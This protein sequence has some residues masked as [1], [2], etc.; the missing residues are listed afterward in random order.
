VG[1]DFQDWTAF[2]HN[3][4]ARPGGRDRSQRRSHYESGDKLD[5]DG[6]ARAGDHHGQG[7][8]R[9]RRLSGHAD[10]ERVRSGSSRGDEKPRAANLFPELQRESSLDFEMHAWIVEVDN[11]LQVESDLREEI[12]RRFRQARIEVP[13]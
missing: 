1:E 5:P 2:H 3:P 4:D 13:S 12:D 9:V 10:V 7:G 6:S 8:E 11:R